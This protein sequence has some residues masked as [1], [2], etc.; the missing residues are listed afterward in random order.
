MGASF[1]A[2][3]I[4]FVVLAQLA[5]SPG[6]NKTVAKGAIDVALAACI[7]EHPDDDEAALKEACKWADEL[8]PLVKEL[9]GARSKG[10][11]KHDSSKKAACAQPPADAGKD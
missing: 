10:I 3:V 7:A 1:G 11:A 6:L 9:I 8:A 4:S 5:C 2:T